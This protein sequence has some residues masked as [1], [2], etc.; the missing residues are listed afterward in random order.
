MSLAE[1]AVDPTKDVQ[2]DVVIAGG[3]TYTLTLPART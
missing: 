2:I 1:P 3:Q